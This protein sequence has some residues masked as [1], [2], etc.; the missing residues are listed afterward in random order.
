MSRRLILH[1]GPPKTGTS[2]L[3]AHLI[4]APPTGLTY[5]ETGRW[6][7]GAHHLL[8][9]S[10]KGIGQ[11]GA[12]E[13]PPWDSLHRTLVHE[14]DQI[15][16]DVILSSELLDPQTTPEFLNAVQNAVNEP[17]ETVQTLVVLRH[18]LERS[19]SDYNQNIKD[20]VIWEKRFPD[21]YLRETAQNH[22]LAGYVKKWTNC[23]CPPTFVS[24]HP[25]DTLLGRIMDAM[26]HPQTLET[27]PR[28]NR[29]INGFGVVAL[30]A[31]HRL[32]L[33]P[34]ARATLFDTLRKARENRIWSGDSFPFSKPASTTYLTDIKQ[35][36]HDTKTLTGIDLT[37]LYPEPPKRFRLTP[38]QVSALVDLFAPFDLTP[39]KQDKLH[40]ILERFAPN[41][42][43]SA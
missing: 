43:P 33:A 17:F 5:P 3:Q 22:R 34:E 8:T 1:C 42:R 19:A 13:I 26:G 36:L 2:A 35:D 15:Q 11:R 24:Y 10:F 14:L 27:A 21:K 18:P 29:S 31:A 40:H 16:G 39:A 12:I 23:A 9:F 25:A 37:G 20:P 7:D 6:P 41:K 32:D 30:L 38:Q 28:R 4:A